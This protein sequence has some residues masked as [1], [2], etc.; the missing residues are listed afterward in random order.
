M[1]HVC[2][3]TLFF[4]FQTTLLIDCIKSLSVFASFAEKIKSWISYFHLKSDLSESISVNPDMGIPENNFPCNYPVKVDAF[5]EKVPSEDLA[6]ENTKKLTLW[7]QLTLSKL[8]LVLLGKLLPESK[9]E[10]KCI[11]K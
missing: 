5:N 6:K 8:S 4:K 3:Y 7:S 9:Y 10:S 11:L 2:I 1:L